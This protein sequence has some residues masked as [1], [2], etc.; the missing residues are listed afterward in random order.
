MTEEPVDFRHPP[1]PTSSYTVLNVHFWCVHECRNNQRFTSFGIKN[2][3]VRLLLKPHRVIKII[4]NNK[5]VNMTK[6]KV[7]VQHTTIV[8]MFNTV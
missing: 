7:S 4:K 5:Q 1:P 8:T 3:L 6:T 2:E